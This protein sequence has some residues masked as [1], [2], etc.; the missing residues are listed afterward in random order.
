MFTNGVA[1]LLDPVSPQLGLWV[2]SSDLAVPRSWNTWPNW[3]GHGKP[4][5]HA[6]H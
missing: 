2:M 3:R 4:E 6:I 5:G 1:H